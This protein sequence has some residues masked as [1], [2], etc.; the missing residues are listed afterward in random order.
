MIKLT[1]IG[2]A[3]KDLK[4]ALKIFSDIFD[5]KLKGDEIRE[6]GPGRVRLATIPLGDTK[7]ELVQP[8]SKDHWVTDIIADRGEGLYHISLMVDD[9]E[10]LIQK[11]EEKGYKP[12]PGSPISERVVFIE[13]TKGM[14]LELV[15]SKQ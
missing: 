7:I 2:V 5:L 13:V 6:L 11:L 1:H 15:R 8:I 9:F 12:I 4:K 3:V 10:G 14:K